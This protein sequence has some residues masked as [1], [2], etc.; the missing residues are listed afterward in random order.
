MVFIN[1][2]KIYNDMGL[3]YHQLRHHHNAVDCFELALELELPDKGSNSDT[4]QKQ[5]IA[6]LRQNLGAVFNQLAQFE[7]ALQC[8][9][10]AVQLHGE[11]LK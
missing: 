8:H 10:L 2:G 3:V 11:L 5:L 7:K 9:E 1:L 6:V 4:E